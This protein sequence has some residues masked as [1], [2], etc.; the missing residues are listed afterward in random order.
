MNRPGPSSPVRLM[1]GRWLGIYPSITALLLVL[2]PFLLGRFPT[3]LIALLLTA[4]LVP[5][6]HYVMF[7]LVEHLTRG[8]VRFPALLGAAH[9]RVAL[10]VWAV[11]YPLITAVLLL[12]LPVLAGHTPVPVITL[13]VTLIAVP[14]QSLLILPRLMPRALPWILGAQRSPA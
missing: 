8:W 14:L 4:V 6:T 1:V 5:L 7:P 10:L 13:V 2:G 12:V 3:P 9:H 11:T